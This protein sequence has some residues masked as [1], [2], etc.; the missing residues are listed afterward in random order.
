M[1]KITID[2]G[3][4]NNGNKPWWIA[5]ATAV[6]GAVS[7]WLVIKGRK[8]EEVKAHEKKKATDYDYHQKTKNFDWKLEQTKK[9]YYEEEAA[10][11]KAQKE[12][13]EKKQE[14]EMPKPITW[15]GLTVAEVEQ[16]Y[17]NVEETTL[18]N[19]IERSDEA[20][21]YVP[22]SIYERGTTLIAGETGSGKTTLLYQMLIDLVNQRASTLFPSEHAVVP[23]YTIMP[24]LLDSENLNKTGALKDRYPS[25]ATPGLEKIQYVGGPHYDS[26]DDFKIYC[27]K[28]YQSLKPGD[29]VILCLDNAT[30]FGKALSSNQVSSLSTF[31]TTSIMFAYEHNI[32]LTYVL[33]LHVNK[34][35][36]DTKAIDIN[37]LSGSSYFG[38]LADNVIILGNTALGENDKYLKIEK[39]RIDQKPNGVYHLLRV[40]KDK[41]NDYLHFENQGLKQ[42]EELL[43]KPGGSSGTTVLE[44]ET[45]ERVIELSKQGFSRKEIIEKLKISGPTVDKYRPEE[46]KKKKNK[47]PKK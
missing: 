2:T 26:V 15:F 21:C 17:G 22:Y 31:F 5:L 34:D 23:K 30:V 13:E 20:V 9:K 4:N 46:F 11:A 35:K 12:A 10:K 7:T 27:W 39:S 25:D 42:I 47:K 36:A 3:N 32:R 37:N 1:A 38:Y 44:L 18:G 6:V 40:Q 24:I 28:R 41:E 45:K 43:S 16:K 8:I 19:A 14:E 29:R 33:V